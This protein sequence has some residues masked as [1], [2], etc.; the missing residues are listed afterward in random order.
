MST[1]RIPRTPAQQRFVTIALVAGI[2]VAAISALVV[3]LNPDLISH[4]PPGGPIDLIPT[5]EAPPP[6]TEPQITPTLLN[7]GPPR[8]TPRRPWIDSDEGSTIRQPQVDGTG[9]TALPPHPSAF[10]PAR[11][12]FDTHTTPD[13]PPI[14][15]RLSEQG[16][17]RLS[18]SIDEQG[19]VTDAA[20]ITSSGYDALDRAAVAWV[21]AHWR[22]APAL[23]DG[24]PIPALTSAVVTFRLT[25]RQG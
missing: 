13:Y 1:L 14:A 20:V 9:D 2:H 12:I 10:V 15:A 16:S 24:V 21:R 4:V 8:E 5:H 3:A 18:L 22:Y 25:N 11:P 6:K 19:Y 7:P 17:V 23:K